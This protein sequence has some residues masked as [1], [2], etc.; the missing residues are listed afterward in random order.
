MAPHRAS[1]WTASAP[2]RRVFS[3]PG[4]GRAAERSEVSGRS[5]GAAGDERLDAVEQQVQAEGEVAVVGPAPRAAEGALPHRRRQ[6]RVGGGV[7]EVA[8]HLAVLL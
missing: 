2:A 8:E 1:R 5:A 4:L 6:R 7:E 3:E